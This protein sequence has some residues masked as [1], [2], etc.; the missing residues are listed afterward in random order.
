MSD[1][2][3]ALYLERAEYRDCAACDDRVHPSDMIGEVCERCHED[4]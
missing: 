3:L 2:D 4:D 1:Y